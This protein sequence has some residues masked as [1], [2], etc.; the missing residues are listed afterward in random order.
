[1]ANHKNLC[2]ILFAGLFSIGIIST[3]NATLVTRLGGL[4]VYD[5][6][7]DITW[8]ADANAAAGTSFDDGFN[9]TDG[10]MTWSSAN[11]WA[12][13]LD[14]GGFTDWR[15]PSALNLDGSAPCSGSNC[16][17]SE[18]GNLFYN[19]LDGTAGNSLVSSTD[20]D[21]DLFSNIQN[22]T[23]WSNTEFAS[24]DG[25]AWAFGTEIGNQF[26]SDKNFNF[27][28]WAVR[29][30]DVGASAIPEPGTISLIGLSLAGLLGLRRRKHQY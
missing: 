5:T 24:F 7:R 30:G 10:L 9:T 29:T 16:T 3:A 19:E 13:S 2:N 12:A 17:D 22:Y 1:M 26:P 11:A 28:A 23:Y 25:L 4:A 6:E 21:L 20:P 27:H 14:V 8:L 18:M 15:L